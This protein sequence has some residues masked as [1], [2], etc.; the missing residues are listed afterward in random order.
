MTTIRLFVVAFVLCLAFAP[1]ARAQIWTETGDAGDLVPSAQTTVGSGSMTQI[2]GQLAGLTDVDVYCIRMTAVLPA[3]TPMIQLQCAVDNGPNV[4]MFDAAGN[5]VFTNSRCQFGFKTL[6]APNVSLA[7]GVYY[8][9][10]SF[11]GYDPQSAGG[12]IWLAGIP[13]Q[14]APDGPGAAG[15]LTG[16]AG[17]P[18]LQSIN[19]YAIKLS[20][21]NFCEEPTAVSPGSWGRVKSLYR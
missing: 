15:T 8:V 18:V 5:G 4:W 6:L 20:G 12:A 16:W 10:V 14:R 21:M 19:P 7:A 3:N 17:T 2:N 13:G 9:A 1:G 11:S